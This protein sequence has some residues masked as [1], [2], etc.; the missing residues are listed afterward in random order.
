MENQVQVK[1]HF[2]INQIGMISYRP[3]SATIF[4]PDPLFVIIRESEVYDY[5]NTLRYMSKS[6]SM[7]GFIASR[8]PRMVD[9]I[10][11]DIEEGLCLEDCEV[12][13]HENH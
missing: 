9:Y 6:R 3:S 2:R 13:F 11:W 4:I 1:H 5:L 8:P 12:M 7:L 10:R